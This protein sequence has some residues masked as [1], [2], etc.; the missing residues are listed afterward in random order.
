[1]RGFSSVCGRACPEASFNAGGSSELGGAADGALDAEAAGSLAFT[2][3]IALGAGGGGGAALAG[4]AEA[5]DS[6]LDGSDASRLLPASGPE[7]EHA[8]TRAKIETSR[9]LGMGDS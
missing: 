6:A 2:L 9:C 3:A 8:L 7:R 4:T 5:T 1:M